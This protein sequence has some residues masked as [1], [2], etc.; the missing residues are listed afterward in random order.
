MKVEMRLFLQFILFILVSSILS[1]QDNT[2]IKALEDALN[3]KQEDTVRIR[4]LTELAMQYKVADSTYAMKLL[5]ESFELSLNTSYAKGL[6]ISYESM[7]KIKYQH[8]H[9]EP[10]IEYF[11][12]AGSQYLLA[13]ENIK[14]AGV[15]VDEGNACLFLS[16]YTLALSKYE[17]AL[18]IFE[19]LNYKPGMIRCFNNMGIIY[20]NFGEY[21]KALQIYKDVIALSDSENDK[22]SLGDTN[23]NMGVVYVKKGDYVHA[24]EHFNM[25][26]IY[27]EK[28][29]DKGQQ[30][31]SLMNS[32]VIYNKMSNYIKALEYYEKALAISKEIGN[33]VEISKC[34]TNIGTNYISL[35]KYDLAE[36]YINQG[37]AIKMNLGDQRSISNCYNFLAEIHYH[38]S[39]FPESIKM[40]EKAIV[41]KRKVNDP[42]GLARCFSNIS[43]TYFAMGDMMNALRYA[44]SSLSYSSSIGA[45]EHMVS[46]YYLKKEIRK[47]Q[48]KYKDAYELSELHKIYSDSLLYENNV[49][50]IN[51]IEFRYQAQVLEEENEL[52]HLQ[53]ELDGVLILR[54]RKVLIIV[55]L[56]LGMIAVSIVLLS[57][58][59]RKQKQYNNS[60]EKKNQIITKQ[61]IKLDAINRTKDKILSVI[62]HD[63]RGTIG[64]QIT[65]LSVLAKEEFKNK[66]EKKL[67]FSQLANSATHSIDIL[68]NLTLWTKIQEGLIS[69]HPEEGCIN[70]TFEEVMERFQDSIVHKDLKLTSEIGNDCLCFYDQFMIKSVIKN[71]ASNAIK[72]S[73]RGGDI[74]YGIEANTNY[75]RLCIIDSGIGISPGEISQL[76]LGEVSNMRRGTENEKGS[77]L[78]LSIVKSFLDSH[79]TSLDIESSSA[80]TKVSFRLPLKPPN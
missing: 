11:Q 43:R 21:E 55:L 16:E 51:E 42:E 52:L 78:G 40:D 19:D 27:A 65:A 13:G 25:A 30:A 6:G 7:G 38:E 29:G 12:K 64:N 44:D 56:V 46:A 72:F 18:K 20:K 26:L 1:A 14:F 23:I 60:L 34:L 53:S 48:G 45:L 70:E 37:L 76:K 66:D 35:E 77:G 73:H 67:V 8:G 50:T 17:E 54:H 4:L 28:N 2:A 41:I 33:K 71:L 36:D 9:Y 63:L 5:N 80:G 74:H 10:A 49:I 68:E 15:I 59:Q 3:E 75:F 61:N 79:N 22:E 47:S 69:Y 31:I 32:G 39:R 24:L 57:I 62:T 58:I